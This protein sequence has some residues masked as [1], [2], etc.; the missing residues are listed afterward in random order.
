MACLLITT[1]CKTTISTYTSTEEGGNQSIDFYGPQFERTTNWVGWTSIAACTFGGAYAGYR[2]NVALD[3]RL[4]GE[5]YIQHGYNAALGGLSGFLVSELATSLFGGSAPNLTERTA[6]KWL[7][8]VN[9]SLL[10]VPDNGSDSEEILMR[11]EGIPKTADSGFQFS[12]DDDVALFKSVFTHGSRWLSKD[13]ESSAIASDQDFILQLMVAFPNSATREL[14]TVYIDKTAD[15]EGL[16]KCANNWPEMKPLIAPRLEG[17]VNNA[18]RLSTYEGTFGRSAFTDSILDSLCAT[19]DADELLGLMREFPEANSGPNHIRYLNQGTTT[20]D[21]IEASKRFPD[22]ASQAES[23]A[24]K[25]VSVVSDLHAYLAEFPNGLHAKVALDDIDSVEFEGLRNVWDYRMYLKDF[26]NGM[27][28]VDVREKLTAAMRIPENLGSQINTSEME[29]NGL[30]SPDGTTLYFTRRGIDGGDEQIWT[31]ELEENG[32]WSAAAQ[33]DQLTNE[34]S[35]D[36]CSVTPDGNT[37]LLLNNYEPAEDRPIAISHRTEDGWSQPEPQLVTGYYNLA[38]PGHIAY[39][40][41]RLGPDSRT[42]VMASYQSKGLGE[43][44]LYVSFQTSDGVWSKP[45]NLGS[46]INT[47]SDDVDPFLAADGKTLYFSTNGRPGYGGYDIFMSRRLDDSWVRWSKPVNLGPTVNTSG[48]DQFFTIPASGDYVYFSSDGL[49]G[50]GSS[51]LFRVALPEQF[52]P[53]PLIL[54]AGVVIEEGSKKPLGATI[55]YEDL[56][57]GKEI[58]VAR[59]DPKTGA[60]KIALV[61]GSN[62]GFRAEADN[63][64]PVSENI[65]LT[66]LTDY[67][68]KKQNLSLVPLEVGSTVRLNNLFFDFNKASLRS[69]SVPELSRLADLMRKYSTMVIDIQGHTDSVG[70]AEYN[71]KLSVERATAVANYLRGHG[72]QANRLTVHG[73]GFTK[74]ASTNIS[75]EGRQLNRR[76]EFVISKI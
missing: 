8:G 31:S 62:Y 49:G 43:H 73:F 35:D 36:V 55:H 22:I 32:D 38:E 48:D 75:E 1:S 53:L 42:L 26:P 29:Y 18:D 2:A 54:I 69:E 58:G 59:S 71:Q 51:D 52:R 25:R 12:N 16:L 46:T 9:R 70:T 23:L 30:I 57:T 47:K 63:Y 7:L 60:Y 19:S 45:R 10:V 24:F 11:V 14:R 50:E 68:E 5:R 15:W 66:N 74:P 37:L 3:W 65:D 76:V 21:A 44:D 34:S 4:N 64:I 33:L 20:D 40:Q 72:V 28:A 13:L 27:H 61:A 6:N 56:A 39:H 17:F 41:F 67:G